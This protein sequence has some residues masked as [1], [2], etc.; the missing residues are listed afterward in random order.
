MRRLNLLTCPPFH[1]P[2]LPHVDACAPAP[3][4]L[5]HP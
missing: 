5:T 1:A 4:R 3:T 2:M